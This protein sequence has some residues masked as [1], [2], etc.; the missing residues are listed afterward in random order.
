MFLDKK[1]FGVDTVD[2][3]FQPLCT[4][5]LFV[6]GPLL[7]AISLS[8]WSFVNTL[9]GPSFLDDAGTQYHFS[10]FW[11]CVCCLD[12]TGAPLLFYP[13]PTLGAP[14][15]ALLHTPDTA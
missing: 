7:S 6:L 8:F 14:L 15:S 5:V 1:P 13:F 4:V 3:L 10:A 12:L 11:S 9:W 2:P